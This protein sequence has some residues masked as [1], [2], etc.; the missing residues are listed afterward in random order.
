VAA[1]NKEV[2]H[3][4]LVHSVHNTKPTTNFS[5]TAGP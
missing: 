5:I 4:S 1:G 3:K 2:W